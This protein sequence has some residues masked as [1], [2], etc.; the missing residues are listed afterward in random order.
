MRWI[1]LLLW[2]KLERVTEIKTP[3][4]AECQFVSGWLIYIWVGWSNVKWNALINNTTHLLRCL[5]FLLYVMAFCRTLSP[6]PQ[7]IPPSGSWWPSYG[8][9]GSRGWHWVPVVG[10]QRTCS[11][12][13]RHRCCEPAH[14][15]LRLSAC[16]CRLWQNSFYTGIPAPGRQL[17]NI[18][19]TSHQVYPI[20]HRKLLQRGN[21]GVTVVICWQIAAKGV[22]ITRE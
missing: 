20:W 4:W 22:Y 3:N 21:G 10:P 15:P 7:D 11:W 9:I 14:T 17:S 5:R 16:L 1:S 19:C 18:L 2:S 13:P 6:A 12:F 8:R